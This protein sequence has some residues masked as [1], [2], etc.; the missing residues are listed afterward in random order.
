MSTLLP[1]RPLP[2]P[3]PSHKWQAFASEC[4]QV[5]HLQP[6]PDSVRVTP[7]SEG[8]TVVIGDG[9]ESQPWCTTVLLAADGSVSVQTAASPPG[10]LMTSREVRMVPGG[11]GGVGRARLDV[12]DRLLIMSA[13]ALGALPEALGAMRR[14]TTP[15]VNTASPG[16]LLR[17]LLHDLPIG[18]AAI[19]VRTSPTRSASGPGAE[20]R[21][22]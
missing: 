14:S 7:G 13:E 4:W 3:R 19:A 10:V 2:V 15:T 18:A 21:T 5:H 17:R 9:P 6:T 1:A 20:A 22:R 16:D 8:L 12:G 11:P